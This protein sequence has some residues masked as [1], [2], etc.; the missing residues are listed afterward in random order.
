MSPIRLISFFVLMLV[1]NTGRGVAV[2][3]SRIMVWG[4]DVVDGD[5][6]GTSNAF[7][8]FSLPSHRKVAG[9]YVI[10]LITIQHRLVML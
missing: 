1:I 2:S 8:T 10:P 7:N 6:A 5:E 9:L 4:K 3:L